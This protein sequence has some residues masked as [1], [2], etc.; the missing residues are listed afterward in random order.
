MYAYLKGTLIESSPSFVTLEVQGIGFLVSITP[1]TFNRLGQIGEEARLFTSFI[2][3]E[4][5]Q[6]LYGF[7]SA[8]EKTLFE[9]LLDV[10][11]VGPK[12]GLALTG[13]LTPEEFFGAITRQDITLLSKVPGI[14]KKTA[15]R[16]IL[17][18]KDK[19][20][21]LMAHSPQEFQVSAHFDQ[22]SQ[23]ALSALINLG[24]SS[25]IAQKAITKTVKDS[26]ETLSLG[27]LITFALKH[28]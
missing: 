2:V 16:L 19:T 8:P 18:L 11:G 24:Y 15:E 28:I 26:A 27:Q 4:N 10:S 21:S 1:H 6:A 20:K 9:A 13:H 3:R 23:D 22:T 12:T 7:L 5:S 17:D 14:G 25:S